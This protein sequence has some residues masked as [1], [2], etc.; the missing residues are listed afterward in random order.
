LFI[1]QNQGWYRIPV[2]KKPKRW[3]PKYLAF[4]QPK[5][6][7]ED[8]FK[9]RYFG[10]VK[11]IEVVKRQE[12]FPNEIESEKSKKQYCRLWLEHLQER[13]NPIPSRFPRRIVFVPTT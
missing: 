3:P 12:I 6:F 4:Y 7:G 5:A 11:N 13:E 2:A 1:L 9:V 8:A 10:L